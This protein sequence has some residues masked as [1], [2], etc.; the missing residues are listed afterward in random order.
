MNEHP[1]ASRTGPRFEVFFDGE[2]PL[3]VREIRTL[4]RLDRSSRIR[5]T[6]IASPSFD[7]RSLGVAP[8]TLMARIHGRALGG[9]VTGELVEGVEVFR[10]LYAAV[11]LGPLVALTRL[12]GVRNAL[13]AG[14]TLF[15]KNRLWLTGRSAEECTDRCVV[16]PQPTR[17]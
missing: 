16:Q 3:C 9:G 14:Y 13:D 4:Q 11:G 6:D 15:A 5:F 12:P 2:C 7:A 17:S 1:T 10:Q 8:S